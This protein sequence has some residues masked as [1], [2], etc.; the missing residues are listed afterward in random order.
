MILRDD[1]G[2]G[3]SSFLFKKLVSFIISFFLIT[4]VKPFQV[5]GDHCVWFLKANIL[6]PDYTSYYKENPSLT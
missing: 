4:K 5:F 3:T 6:I 1:R 2:H